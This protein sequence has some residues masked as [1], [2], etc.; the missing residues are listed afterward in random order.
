[1]RRRKQPQ[2]GD[3]IWHEDVILERRVTGRVLWK[4]ASFFSYADEEGRVRYCN[5]DEQYDVVCTT[6]GG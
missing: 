1:V 5:Y 4:G 3:T 6:E 2:V